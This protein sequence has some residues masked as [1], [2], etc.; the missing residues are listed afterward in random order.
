MLKKLIVTEAVV[1][2]KTIVDNKLPLPVSVEY[3]Q[4]KDKNLTSM[5]VKHVK[6]L[7]TSMLFQ[8]ENRK[9]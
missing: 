1:G 8:N 9:S 2:S 7:Q 6:I 5:F 4:K 3:F